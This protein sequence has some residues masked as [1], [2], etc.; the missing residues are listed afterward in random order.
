MNRVQA[1]SIPGDA[2]IPIALPVVEADRDATRWSV[3]FIL[4]NCL[5]LLRLDFCLRGAQHP[6][7]GQLR[8]AFEVSLCLPADAEEGDAVQELL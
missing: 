6:P 1:G 7:D 2:R 8:S 4:V 3:C 5:L